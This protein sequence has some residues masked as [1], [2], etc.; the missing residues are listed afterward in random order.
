M[1]AAAQPQGAV[2]GTTAV[3]DQSHLITADEFGAPLFRDV[4]YRFNVQLY[5]GQ[6]ACAEA[7]PRVRA[8]LAQE[9][10][11]HTAYQ[12][13]IVEPRMRIGYQSRIG[14]DTVVG[15]VART[16]SLGSQQTLGEETV[17]AGPVSTRLGQSRLG[18]ST[19]VG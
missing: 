10:P 3:L 13:S 12:I 5:R 7:L 18:L 11:A 1:L 19:R 9:M 6:L 14:I 15:G 16:F 17:L 4:A 8:V 2:V